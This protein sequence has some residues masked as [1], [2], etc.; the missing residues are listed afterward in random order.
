MAGLSTR[1]SLTYAKRDYKAEANLGG[2]LP[3][4][5]VRSDKVYGAQL[6]VWKRDWH[7]FGL[8]PKVRFFWR[9]HDSN[10]PSLYSYT[11]KGVQVLVEAQF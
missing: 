2:L 3:L 9:K 10:L 1:T 11:N 6:T 5:K 7:L 4:G 8:T